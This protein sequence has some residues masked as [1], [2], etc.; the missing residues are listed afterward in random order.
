LKK[1]RVLVCGASGFIGRNVCERLMGRDDLEVLGT[2]FKNY[3]NESLFANFLSSESCLHHTRDIDIIIQCAAAT[4]GSGMKDSWLEY[5]D[6]NIQMNMNLL[7][8][9][10][11]N[12][13]KH[14]I[15]LSCSVMYP[16]YFNRP[17]REDDVIRNQFHLDYHEGAL[18]KLFI[19]DW[20]YAYGSHSDMSS[21]VIRHSNIYGPHDKFDLKHS[22]VCGA[23]IT[24]AMTSTDGKLHIRG[25]GTERRDLLYVSDLVDFIE[26]ATVHPPTGRH[27]KFNVGSG[28]GVP[29][30]NLARQII[31]ASGRDLEIVYEEAPSTARPASIVLDSGLAKMFTGWE[32]KVSLEEGLKKTIEWWDAE[33]PLNHAQRGGENIGKET[34]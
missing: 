1:K 5:A 7:N 30:H 20:C 12:G 34:K 2:C 11:K 13:V 17:V 8:A 14:F 22:H 33:R 29:V 15:F 19:E 27:A 23:L 28:V 16:P 10:A 4:A 32:P 6:K 26:Y 25:D 3:H 18:A 9:V 31:A 21:T 24:K